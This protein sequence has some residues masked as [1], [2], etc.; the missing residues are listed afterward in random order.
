MV[1]VALLQTC[2]SDDQKGMSTDAQRR[3]IV[4]GTGSRIGREDSI[5][6]GHIAGGAFE[7]G[8]FAEDSPEAKHIAKNILHLVGMSE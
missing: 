4:E 3:G 7:L 2:A 8:E 6:I 1:T 5:R